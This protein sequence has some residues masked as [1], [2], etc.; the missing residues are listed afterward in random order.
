M[1][2]AHR[3]AAVYILVCLAF[4]EIAKDGGVMLSCHHHIAAPIVLDAKVC[5]GANPFLEGADPQIK[6]DSEV[7]LTTMRR[8]QAILVVAIH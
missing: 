7:C 1:L 5:R 2:A 8:I 4:R 6:P 3:I